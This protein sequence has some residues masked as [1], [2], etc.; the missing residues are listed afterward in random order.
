MRNA[1]ATTG[2]C[3]TRGPRSGESSV[4]SVCFVRT[5][6]PAVRTSPLKMALVATMAPLLFLYA[7][8][9]CFILSAFRSAVPAVSSC[10]PATPSLACRFGVKSFFPCFY[11][12]SIYLCAQTL[13]ECLSFSERGMCTARYGRSSIIQ[14]RMTFSCSFKHQSISRQSFSI[15]SMSGI[16]RYRKQYSASFVKC[17]KF[18]GKRLFWICRLFHQGNSNGKSGA[19]SRDLA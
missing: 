15:S 12:L 7:L 2:S 1:L 16:I 3:V 8:F 11:L 6:L 18:V 9:F 4:T 13:S 10:K 17:L 14:G 19:R 5:L